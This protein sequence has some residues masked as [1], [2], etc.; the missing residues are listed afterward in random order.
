MKLIHSVIAL[1]LWILPLGCFIIC[2]RYWVD[3]FC[4]DIMNTPL[5][6][7]AILLIIAGLG[8]YYSG[9]FGRY[10]M[11]NYHLNHCNNCQEDES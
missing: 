6:T 3:Y 9:K 2:Q 10:L 7:I 11:I 4:P 1:I 5:S 8:G